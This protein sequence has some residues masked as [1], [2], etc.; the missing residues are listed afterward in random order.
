MKNG[1]RTERITL[2]ISEEKRDRARRLKAA[3]KEEN[4]HFPV[5][6]QNAWLNLILDAGL[7][8]MIADCR[9][10]QEA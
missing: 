8:A 2:Y 7:E 10:H 5:V 4:I 1:K 9:L 6:S 3:M